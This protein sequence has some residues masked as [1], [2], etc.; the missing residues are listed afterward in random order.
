MATLTTPPDLDE[1]ARAGIDLVNELIR[2]FKV[3]RLYDPSHPQRRESE[4][5]SDARI[6]ALLRDSRAIDFTVESER[7]LVD[8]TVVHEQPEGRDSIVFLLYREGV[9]QLSFYPGLTGEELGVFVDEVASAALAGAEDQFDLVARLWERNFVHIRY[10][11]VEQLHDQDW[12]PPGET[13]SLVIGRDEQPIVLLEED[14]SAADF[15]REVDPSIYFLDDEDM[16]ALQREIQSEKERTYLHETLTCMLEVLHA[17]SPEDP[18]PIFAAIGDIQESL[19]DARQ[20]EEVMRLHAIFEP[21]LKNLG[22]A[23]IP[24]EYVAVLDRTLAAEVLHRLATRVEEA[25]ISEEIAASYYRVLGRGRL[26]TLL[27][28]CG[29]LKRLCQR[30]ALGQAMIDLARSEPNLL[31]SAISDQDPTVACLAAY[32]AGLVAEGTLL[33]PLA[34]AMERGDDALRREALLAVKQIGGG[35]ALEMVARRIEDPDPTV[36]LYALRH[37]VSHRYVPVLPR[38]K[39]Q[40]DHTAGR[41]LTERRLL[42]EA[43]GVLGGPGVVD[44]LARRLRRK[45]GL[46]RK[47]DPEEQACVVIALGGAG[48]PAARAL[49][50]EACTMRHPLVQRAALDVLGAWESGATVR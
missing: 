36:R 40:L 22:E 28:H 17:M 46:L 16:A 3:R 20:Y 43:Y 47:I 31:R 34:R 38:V 10:A 2:A 19:L 48:G 8:D 42:Y 13:E 35:R 11:F 5:Q 18:A 1:R 30:P 32:L 29:D 44:D 45:E 9:R 7:L 39:S 25:K 27:A 24:K 4:A 14:K 33:E 12:T 26:R 50:E 37:V 49:V 41:S 21:Y 6:A 23:K 15:L